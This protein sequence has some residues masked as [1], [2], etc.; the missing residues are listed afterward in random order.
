M[1]EYKRILFAA[2][3]IPSDDNVI[4]ERVSNFIKEKSSLIDLVFAI[5]PEFSYDAGG[6]L[7]LSDACALE[8]DAKQKLT[9]IAQSLDVAPE[10]CHVRTGFVAE[11]IVDVAKTIE[12]DLIVMGSHGRHGIQALFNPSNSKNVLAHA[13]C[14]VLTIKL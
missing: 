6:R 9:A 3:L 11:T 12:A 4:S 5:E 14:D 2:D 13:P 10:R 7:T 8:H 1:K